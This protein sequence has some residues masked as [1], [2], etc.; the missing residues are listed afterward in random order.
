MGMFYFPFLKFKEEFSLF[1]ASIDSNWCLREQYGFIIRS[2][3]RSPRPR[4]AT[5]YSRYFLYTKTC[6]LESI[7]LWLIQESI[8]SKTILKY[9]HLAQC[10]FHSIHQ[11][12]NFPFSHSTNCRR[13][14]SKIFPISYCKNLSPK[15]CC[16]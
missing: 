4:P 9:L 7:D 16:Q 6:A 5:L 14:T 2:S 10:L 11:Y 8:D 1:S 3:W 15:N 12:L 13:W